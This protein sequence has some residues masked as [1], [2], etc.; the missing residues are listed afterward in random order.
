MREARQRALAGD[1]PTLLECR[2]YRLSGHS[3]GDQRRYR[4]REEEAEAKQQDP[5]CRLQ[6]QLF[7]VILLDAEAD[8]SLRA[9]VEAV[10]AEAIAFAE[11]SPFPDPSTLQE[12][13][14]A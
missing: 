9:G 13:V 14:F 4:T 5:I 6:R 1:G 2:T 3:R 8:H 10:V 12:G 11:A 7:D